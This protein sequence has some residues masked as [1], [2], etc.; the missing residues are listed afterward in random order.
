MRYTVEDSLRNFQFWSGGK[1]RADKCSSSELDEIESFLEE[2]EPEDGWTDTAIND[3]FWFDFDTLAQ[4][5]GYKDE[6]DF[7]LQH[8]PNYVDDDELEEY[9]DKWFPKLVAKF[10]GNCEVLYNLIEALGLDG[11][12]D[13]PTD[14]DGSQ[15][16]ADF[17]IQHL[18]NDGIDVMLWLFDDDNGHDYDTNIPTKKQLR[19]EAMAEKEN[20]NQTEQK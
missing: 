20:N 13:C 9:I 7:D 15:A 4:H 19:K 3:M 6:E 8:D 1:D 16:M 2:I 12:D 17:I 10:A 11:E 18:E 5:L 14:K